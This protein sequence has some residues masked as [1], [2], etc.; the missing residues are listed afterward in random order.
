M[1]ALGISSGVALAIGLIAT[2]L[3]IRWLKVQGIGQQVRD[4][5]PEAHQV[6]RGTPTMGG[7]VIVFAA[8]VGYFT[9]HMR[10]GAYFSRAGLF[11]MLAVAMAALV[12]L[13]DDW[14]KVRHQHSGGLNKR[15]KLAGQ[16]IVAVGFSFAVIT[17]AN[18]HTTLSFT[19]FDSIGF[20]LGRLGW[21]A[22]AVFMVLAT[23]NAVNFTDGLDGLAA[24]SSAFAFSTLTLI[25]YWQFRHTEV[26]QVPQALDLALAAVA[27]S[28]AC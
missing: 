27:F 20:D 25:G 28:G 9:A 1:I 16:I 26:Y 6:K 4:F 21:V 2:P 13:A 15:A 19:R 11:V 8:E 17:W 24:G 22:L 5:L 7:I 14:I 3:F 10:A 23:T 12:G 18:V